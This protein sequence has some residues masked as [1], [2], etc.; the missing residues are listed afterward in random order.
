MADC[1]EGV[2][3]QAG[4]SPAAPAPLTE[5][6]LD[7]LEALARKVR[8]DIAHVHTPLAKADLLAEALPALLAEVRAQRTLLGKALAALEATRAQVRECDTSLGVPDTPAA[9]AALRAAG[10]EPEP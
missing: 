8:E 9:D 3:K 4:G 7:A 5:E 6:R 10:V 1:A 2:K